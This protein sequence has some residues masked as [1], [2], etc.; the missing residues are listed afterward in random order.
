MQTNAA[1]SVLDF[2]PAADG[3]PTLTVDRMNQARLDFIIYGHKNIDLLLFRLCLFPHPQHPAYTAGRRSKDCLRQTRAVAGAH[4][5]TIA[6]L[7]CPALFCMQSPGSPFG[8]AK[9][10]AGRLVLVRAGAA[11]GYAEGTLLGTRDDALSTLGRVHSQKTAE[12]LMDLQARAP[13]QAP[14]QVPRNKHRLTVTASLLHAPAG[15][16]HAVFRSMPQARCRG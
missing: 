15:A 3:P 1:T 11:E 16:E 9:A 10:G 12:L 8:S 5:A 7:T 14:T 13:D 6:A 2:A 4:A